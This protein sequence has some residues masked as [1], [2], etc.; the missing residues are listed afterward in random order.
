MAR[1]RPHPAPLALALAIVATAILI[2]GGGAAASQSGGRTSTPSR[3]VAV[4]PANLEAAMRMLLAEPSAP[5]REVSAATLNALQTYY[6]RTDYTPVWV[7]GD[8]LTQRGAA[9]I[10]ALAKARD[11][12]ASV[13]QPIMVAVDERRAA[14]D[15]VA[16]AELEILLSGALLD[17]AA[18]TFDP[19]DSGPLVELLPAAVGAPDASNF[20]RERL[21]AD[22]AFWR[23]RHAA[24]M[25]RELAD[26]GGWPAVPAGPTLEPGMRDGRIVAVRARLAASGELGGADG[27]S[28]LYDMPLR[29][30]VERF[31]SR[32]GLEV[33]GII[34]SGTLEALNVPVEARL[35]TMR[36]NLRRLQ[37]QGREWGASYI[38]VNIAAASYRLVDDGETVFEQVAI[39]GQPDWQTPEV[40]SQ[41]ERIELNPYWTV[42]ER[43]ARLE[44]QPAIEKDP[45]YL[46]KHNMQQVGGRYRQDPGNDN[47]LGKAKFLFPN[48]YDVYLHDTNSHRLF[49]RDARFLSHGCVRIPNAVELAEALLRD[50]PRW[51]REK[52][53]A[54]IGRGKNRSITLKQPMPVHIVYETAWV[55][56]A[57]VVEFRKDIY[58][59]DREL[60]VASTN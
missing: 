8:G 37:Q 17:A 23:L 60:Q 41:I 21:P 16:R 51:T 33:D 12:G 55:D 46:A 31:Q 30:A 11:A 38:A 28:D 59:R 44:V 20:L 1:F 13:L 54:T 24:A 5:L 9:L 48:P 50:D 32:H 3:A 58:G 52:I 25:Y 49:Q 15:P 42:P 47:A 45:D 7:D 19:T 2:L 34:G 10:S 27:A 29:H 22:A 18:D 53:D 4:A 35:A 39:V 57:G 14:A 6:G 56:E 36:A 43:I 26:A 40:D